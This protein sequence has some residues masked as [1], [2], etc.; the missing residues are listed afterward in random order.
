MNQINKE[1]PTKFNPTVFVTTSEHD[2]RIHP[3]HHKFVSSLIE[4]K[5]YVYGSYYRP[6]EFWLEHVFVCPHCVH[7]TL[8]DNDHYECDDCDDFYC[9]YCYTDWKDINGRIMMKH[10]EY[11][12]YGD[13]VSC[14]WI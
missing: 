14:D 1:V 8:L 13:E 2:K 3:K 5:G 9:K 4:E 11:N 12:D 10:T 7:A 6:S